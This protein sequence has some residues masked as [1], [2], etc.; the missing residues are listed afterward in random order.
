M[1]SSRFGGAGSA[2]G[3]RNEFESIRMFLK[4]E[5]VIDKKK[6]AD[7]KNFFVLKNLFNDCLFALMENF[8]SIIESTHLIPFD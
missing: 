3:N 5:G 6:Y 1:R 2:N 4:G 8:C 7:M